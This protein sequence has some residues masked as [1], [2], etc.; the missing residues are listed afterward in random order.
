[1]LRIDVEPRIAYLYSNVSGNFTLSSA[2]VIFRDILAQAVRYGQHRIFMDCTRVMGEIPSDQR[3]AYGTFIAEEL[4]RV[5]SQ[6][7][8]PPKVAILAVPPVMDYG[9]LTPNGR[10]QLRR[11][12][13]GF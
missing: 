7:S 5:S 13:E 11:T 10:K 12:N 6:F 1:M 8:D 9:R 4:Q 2:Q 3:L